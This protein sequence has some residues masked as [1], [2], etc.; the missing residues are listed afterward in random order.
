MGK[1]IFLDG[2]GRITGF[3]RIELAE[4][5][6][7]MRLERAMGHQLCGTQHFRSIYRAHS[8]ITQG[9]SQSTCL[10]PLWRVESLGP[11][12]P[13]DVF[14]DNVLRALDMH[15]THF[16][17]KNDQERQQQ[18]E[19]AGARLAFVSSCGT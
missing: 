3:W 18:P 14:V 17:M 11:E 13:G 2:E 4:A 10:G 1:V 16:K 7:R 15:P 6:E 19:Y 9:F 5:R 8:R 12:G